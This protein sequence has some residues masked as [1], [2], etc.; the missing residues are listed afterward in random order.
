M[1]KKK[2]IAFKQKKFKPG[3]E[4]AVLYDIHSK[5]WKEEETSSSQKKS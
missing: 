1:M 2:I 3:K 5:E 4:D